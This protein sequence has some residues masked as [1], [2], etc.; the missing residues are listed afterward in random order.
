MRK[1]GIKLLLEVSRNRKTCLETNQLKC[2]H[3]FF[4]VRFAIDADPNQI[5]T[6]SVSRHIDG[7]GIL[8]SGFGK[9]MHGGEL[10]SLLVDKRDLN[11]RFPE[12]LVLDG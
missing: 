2:F 4:A 3:H 5:N 10:N 7:L 8:A 12:G 1:S 6:G 11:L 9:G